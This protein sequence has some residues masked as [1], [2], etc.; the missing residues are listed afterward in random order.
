MEDSSIA[1][2]SAR[3]YEIFLYYCSY[4]RTSGRGAT[5]HTLDSFNFAKFARDCPGLVDEELVTTTDIDIAFARSKGPRGRCGSNQ[6]TAPC[7]RPTYRNL[8]APRRRIS[9]GQFLDALV[10]LAMKKFP[11]L[12]A[13]GAG[14]RWSGLALNCHM[15]ALTLLRPE[16]TRAFST[17]VSSYVLS[18]NPDKRRAAATASLLSPHRDREEERDS[19]TLGRDLG[20]AFSMSSPVRTKGG[21]ARP[22]RGQEQWAHGPGS[23]LRQVAPV[24]HPPR[25]PMRVEPTWVRA[26]RRSRPRQSFVLKV[27]PTARFAQRRTAS[28]AARADQN[29]GEEPCRRGELLSPGTMRMDD[30]GSPIRRCGDGAEGRGWQGERGAL[31]PASGRS[32]RGTGDTRGDR[33]RPSTSRSTRAGQHLTVRIASVPPAAPDL[34]CPLRWRAR[35]APGRKETCSRGWRA[36]P[37]TRACTGGDW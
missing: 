13:W 16:D 1:Q 24:G 26:P 22:E 25:S 7:P 30:L 3:I 9:F 18:G 29:W 6:R 19:I 5:A 21:H 4:G 17:L 8:A 36:P 20:P 12:G 31:R 27:V 2:T 15:P 33:V 28:P 23:A 14:R 11:G 37:P 35:R 32:W 34:R 10:Q